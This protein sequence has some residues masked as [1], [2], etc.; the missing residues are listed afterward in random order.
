MK[1]NVN[2][3]YLKTI[4]N[5]NELRSLIEGTKCYCRSGLHKSEHLEKQDTSSY[6]TLESYVINH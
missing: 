4:I 3:H 6:K 5:D 2:L 1:D